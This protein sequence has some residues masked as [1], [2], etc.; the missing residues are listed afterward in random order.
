MASERLASGGRHARVSPTPGRGSKIAYTPCPRSEPPQDLEL[1]ATARNCL[2]IPM[3]SL[4]TANGPN[5][6]AADV[7]ASASAAAAAAANT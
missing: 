6:K 7:S 3:S 1:A 4:Q 5:S 2:A